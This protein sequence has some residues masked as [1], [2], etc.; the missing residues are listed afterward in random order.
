MRKLLA[1]AIVRTRFGT[2]NTVASKIITPE[3]LVF[4]FSELIRRGVIYYTGS[5]LPV[6][7]FIEIIMRGNSVSHYVDR[8]VFWGVTKNTPKI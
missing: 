4:F 7:I 1:I 8:P 3:I 5:F 2:E 6:I